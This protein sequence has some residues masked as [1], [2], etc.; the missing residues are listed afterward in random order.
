MQLNVGSKIRI[1]EI[2]TMV[3]YVEIADFPPTKK[4]SSSQ[5]ITNRS[6]DSK[7]EEL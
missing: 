7:D 4:D 3:H 1:W 5:N 6:T 2:Q